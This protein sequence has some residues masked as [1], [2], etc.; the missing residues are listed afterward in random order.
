[1]ETKIIKGEMIR[2]QIFGEV[3][4]EVARLHEKYNQ[5]PGIAFIGFSCVPLA[6]YNIP[7]HLQ[8][9]QSVGLRVYKEIL[10]DKASEEDVFDV[11]DRLNADSDIHAIVLLQPLPEH[12]NPVRIVNR[13]DP[14]KEVEGFHPQNMINT[15]IP[16]LK[17]GMYPMCLPTALYEMFREAEFHI[18]EE[19]EWVFV[20]DDGFMTNALTRMIVRSAAS[21]VVPK[22]SPV[23][24]I[25]KNS[26]HLADHIRRAD[27]LVVV[28]KFPEYIKAE[29]IKEG[30]C[31]ID[32][33]SN[34]VKEIP[35]KA[36]PSKQVPII[37]G[38]INVSSVTGIAGSLLPIPGGLMTV[39]MAILFRNTVI[40]FKNCLKQPNPSV[41]SFA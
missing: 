28:T 4:A 15:M 26:V 20:L 25:N 32:I 13:I 41:L 38:G 17:A 33:Y 12:L 36:D 40:A 35:S 34:L 8:M 7:M 11:I 6:K 31:I 1:M 29:W 24:F 30:A 10:D 14:L 21:V 2:D 18:P 3:K 16:D 9:A 5:V 39:V 22:D 19:S 23:M 37:R 27:F